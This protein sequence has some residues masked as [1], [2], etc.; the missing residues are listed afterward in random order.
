MEDTR[1]TK[2][3]E[4]LFEKEVDEDSLKATRE[5]YMVSLWSK[6]RKQNTMALRN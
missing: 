2:R 3:A 6:T 1:Q 4:G 5:N